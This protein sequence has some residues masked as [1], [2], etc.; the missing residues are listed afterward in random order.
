MFLLRM[1]IQNR[2]AEREVQTEQKKV[3]AQTDHRRDLRRQVVY[4]ATLNIFS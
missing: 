2:F 4:C 3:T 1:W